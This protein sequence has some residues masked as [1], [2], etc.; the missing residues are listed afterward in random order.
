L[1]RFCFSFAVILAR[2]PITKES[3]VRGS[4]EG[5]I[6]LDGGSRI[7]D[8]KYKL[9]TIELLNLAKN[10]YTYRELSQIIGLPDTVLSRYVKGHV[11]PTMDRALYINKTMQKIMRLEAE[12]QLR[13]RFDDSGYF[14]NTRLISDPL[15]LERAV[16][17][18]VNTFAGARITKILSPA[19]DGVPLAVILAHRLGVKLVIA[20]NTREV[21]VSAFFEE[22]YVPGR[23]A[24]VLSLYVPRDA[25]KRGDCVLIVDDVV[26][27]GDIQMA[28]AR[29]VQRAKGEVTGIYALIGVNGDWKTKMEQALHCPVEVVHH[30]GEKPLQRV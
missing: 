13:I 19:V 25:L 11:L 9:M 18:A 14:N 6:V 21:G 26:D 3:L 4:N 23:S 5:G 15:L 24:M 28:L 27:T 20:K 29:I 22:V 7:S 17:Q 30:I 1:H 2:R 16:Q 10:Y 8:L 12:I